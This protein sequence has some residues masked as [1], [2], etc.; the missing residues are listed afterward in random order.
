MTRLSE[1]D[2]R[3]LGP[4]VL[5]YVGDSVHD[6][7]VRTRLVMAG[8]R[9][10]QLHREAVTKVCCTAQAKA[11]LRME[12]MLSETERDV[13]RRGRNAHAHHQAPKRADPGDYSL[14]TGLEALLGYLYLTGQDLRLEQVLEAMDQGLEGENHALL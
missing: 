2:A 7:H 11:L 10:K 6:L 4:Q 12:A 1:M 13:V 9:A 14:A 3:M 5:A 8:G